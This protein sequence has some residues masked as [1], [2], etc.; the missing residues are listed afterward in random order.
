MTCFRPDRDEIFIVSDSL[1]FTGLRK[2]RNQN[3]FRF[4]RSLLIYSGAGSIKI[5][6]LTER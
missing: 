5:S 2:K 4:F 6:L 1:S 3:V